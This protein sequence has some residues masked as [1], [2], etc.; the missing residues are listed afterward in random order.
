MNDHSLV[1]QNEAGAPPARVPIERRRAA[2]LV[3]MPES[4]R[5][6]IKKPRFA[7]TP[8]KLQE[9]ALHRWKSA[10]IVGTILAG[11][12]FGIA[13]VTY[14]PKYTA[15][16]SMRMESGERRLFPVNEDRRANHETEFRKTQS[17]MI[18][19]RKVLDEVVKKDNV[20]ALTLVRKWNGKDPVI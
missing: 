4:G 18:K 12:G 14:A 20:R 16:S 2:P 15:L 5:F 3:A 9:A 13:W 11:I 17:I 10:I 19:S 8:A 6:G 7:V 1:H